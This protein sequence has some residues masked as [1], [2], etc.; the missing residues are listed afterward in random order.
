MYSIQ[1]NKQGNSENPI[2]LT[3]S[4]T[5]I[6]RCNTKYIF[7]PGPFHLQFR[8]V[9]VDIIVLKSILIPLSRP[10]NSIDHRARLVEW[11]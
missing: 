11:I 3:H 4:Y 2:P 9:C 6:P 1:E 5:V 8:N 7:L 10:V